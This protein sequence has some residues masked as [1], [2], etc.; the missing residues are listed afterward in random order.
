VDQKSLTQLSLE[1]VLEQWCVEQALNAC[2]HVASITDVVNAVYTFDDICLLDWLEVQCECV[3]A[4]LRKQCRVLPYSDVMLVVFV[5]HMNLKTIFQDFIYI[6]N[7]PSSTVVYIYLIT[8]LKLLP[9]SFLF[10]FLTVH[11][12]L[13]AVKLNLHHENVPVI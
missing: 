1:E 3:L 5:V 2:T 7:L 9:C 13:V 10:N 6:A 11:W 4:E 8:N 12:P